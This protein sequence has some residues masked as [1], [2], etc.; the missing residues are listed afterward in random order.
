MTRDK[1]F[2][3]RVRFFLEHAGYSTPPGRL[4]CAWRLAEAEAR[5]IQEGLIFNHCPEWDEWD[6][7][8]PKPKYVL[9]CEVWESEAARDF[10]ACSLAS[11]GMVG[12]NSL[13]DPYLRVVRAEL[14]RDALRLIDESRDAQATEE[15][16]S[17]MTRATYAGVYR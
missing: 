7:D 11:L 9:L 4:A 16:Q 13:A 2:Y 3:D 1:R 5:G 6:A 17:L 12:V 10:G 8:V 14:Y 15:A